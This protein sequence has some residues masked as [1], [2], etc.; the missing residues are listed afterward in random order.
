[1][2]VLI[3]FRVVA[4]EILIKSIANYEHLSFA[5]LDTVSY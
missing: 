2:H 4:I 3:V 1:M 5:T